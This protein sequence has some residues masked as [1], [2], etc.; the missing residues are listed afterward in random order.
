MR[1]HDVQHIYG[2]DRQDKILKE[3]GEEF[4]MNHTRSLAK[5]LITKA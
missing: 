2:R 4:R 3:G 1:F 5:S